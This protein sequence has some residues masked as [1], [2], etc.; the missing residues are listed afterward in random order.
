MIAKLS[1]KYPGAPE[2]PCEAP[3]PLGP[4]V[5]HWVA[6]KELELSYHYGYI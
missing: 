1:I 4:S 3:S 6:I 2:H 5:T